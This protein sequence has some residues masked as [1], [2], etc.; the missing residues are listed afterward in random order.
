MIIGFEQVEIYLLILARVAGL[1][2]EAPVFSARSVPSFVKICTAMWLAAVL[3][4]IVPVKYLPDNMITLMFALILEVLVGY[5]IGFISGIVLQSA[6]AAGDILDIQ[7]GLSVA[8]L[9]SPTTGAQT[10]ITGAFLY[11][12]ALLTFFIVNGHHL[13]ISALYHSYTGIPLISFIDFSRPN[14][15]LHLLGLLGFFWI[16]AI[17]L[18]APILLLIFLID[19]SFGIVS[20]VA[21]QVNVFMLGFQVK[22]TVGIFGLMLISPLLIS[23]IVLL[24]GS[25]TNEIAKTIT[26]LGGR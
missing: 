8:S 21:P 18:C 24:I 17:Q 13:L 23:H 26:I 10:S 7:M 16:S 11:L 4:F 3:W 6:Q 1:F 9:L 19:F 25:T 12:V 14:L 2:I 5:I 15:L 20:R 22:P